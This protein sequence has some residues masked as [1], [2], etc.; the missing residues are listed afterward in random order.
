MKSRTTVVF[1]FLVMTFVL[2]TLTTTASP[3]EVYTFKNL[4]EARVWMAEEENKAKVET[5]KISM[6][7]QRSIQQK[8]WEQG[9][10][11][12]HLMQKS[13]SAFFISMR[14]IIEENSYIGYTGA[15]SA[16]QHAGTGASAATGNPA[17]RQIRVPQQL[18]QGQID[19]L[20]AQI[21]GASVQNFGKGAVIMYP[22]PEYQKVRELLEKFNLYLATVN[23]RQADLLENTNEVI[24]KLIDEIRIRG[25]DHF[26]LL[27]EIISVFNQRGHLMQDQ[28]RL[29]ETMAQKSGYYLAP[30]S[31]GNDFVGRDKVI[32]EGNIYYLGGASGNGSHFVGSQECYWE[33]VFYP[34]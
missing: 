1:A 12:L 7:L 19:A 10:V 18:S 30:H 4:N 15:D 20:T 21:P 22:A 17:M 29:L 31:V 5:Y 24:N 28:M 26:E 6:A 16:S 25:T 13:K 32:V 11:R 34:H 9:E 33:S 27:M 14:E 3:P 23:E 8:T 2:M